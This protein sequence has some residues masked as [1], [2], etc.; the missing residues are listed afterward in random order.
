MEVKETEVWRLLN[1]REMDRRREGRAQDH[2]EDLTPPAPK[3]QKT[4]AAKCPRSEK[5]EEAQ[6]IV[7]PQSPPFVPLVDY[8]DYSYSPR[9]PDCQCGA[10][11]AS[12]S[13]E[14]AS[15]QVPSYCYTPTYAELVPVGRPK[16]PKPGP[17]KSPT[18]GPS[19][20]ADTDPFLPILPEEEL[21]QL[22]EDTQALLRDVPLSV[23]VRECEE[24]EV[25]DEDTKDLPPVFEEDPTLQAPLLSSYHRGILRELWRIQRLLE[26]EKDEL[27]TLQI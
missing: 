1:K 21:R 5:P 25:L 17:S 12:P 13:Q 9:S 7:E 24:S 15:Q 11:V 14:K 26:R 4:I 23:I 18:P 2:E 19:S 27:D 10:P 3:K 16:S 8:H 20:S 6:I 22:E